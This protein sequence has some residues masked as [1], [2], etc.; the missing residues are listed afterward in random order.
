MQ[1][2]ETEVVMIDSPSRDD[3]SNDPIQCLLHCLLEITKESQER[4]EKIESLEK[5]LK[6]AKRQVEAQSVYID[7]LDD[8]ICGFSK[9][10][11][12]WHDRCQ[13]LEKEL[14]KE[15]KAYA[16]CYSKRFDLVKEV[17]MLKAQRE[18]LKDILNRWEAWCEKT[19]G[20]K[21]YA[22]VPELTE[23]KC[24]GCGER[25]PSNQ[26]CPE[27]HPVYNTD[28]LNDCLVEAVSK[29]E[30]QD[31]PSTPKVT[32]KGSK[33]RRTTKNETEYLTR[34]KSTT[35]SK[36]P[37]CKKMKP[38]LRPKTLCEECDNP[39]PVLFDRFL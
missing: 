24:G 20:V 16:C 10:S 36:C 38:I 21:H 39:D 23:V 4:L 19:H 6:E 35:N 15:K 22:D 33:R 18:D 3:I 5:E 17:D 9:A 29:L 32:T 31:K 26:Q 12:D 28:L 14:E 30:K 2:A 37:G 13:V 8:D 11:W 25:Y 27:C 7:K 34:L 1:R